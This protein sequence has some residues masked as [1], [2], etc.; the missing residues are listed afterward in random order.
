[1]SVL[2]PKR[3]FAV[4]VLL[5]LAASALANNPSPRTL[6]RMAFDE[7]TG[8]TV[9]FGG[10]GTLDQATG[11]IHSNAETWLL[12]GL[13]WAQRFPTTS[14]SARAAHSM[15]YD[16]KRNRVILFGGFTDP[17]S[18][19]G[20]PT[21]HNDT[22]VWENGNWTE[23]NT[24]N[25]PEPRYY[26]GI[27]YDSD[28]DR[29]VLYGG[30]VYTSDNK[31]T[32]A[33]YD[34]WEFDGTDW[35][36]VESTGAQKAGK[37]ALAYDQ[38]RK[39][40]LLVGL[41]DVLATTMFIYDAESKTWK[42]PSP[43]PDK[44]PSCANEGMMAYQKHKKTIG[45]VGGTCTA[46][47][48]TA[49]ELWEWNG[50]T[51]VKATINAVDRIT[52]AAFTYDSL[53]YRMLLFGGIIF[54]GSSPNSSMQMLFNNVWSYNLLTY[55][56][57]PRSLGALRTDSANGTAWL[58]GGLNEY[59]TGYTGDFWRYD[60]AGQ[61]LPITV[62]GNGPPSGCVTPL[63]A[64]DSNRSRF[65]VVCYGAELFEWNGSAWTSFSSVKSH[66]STRRFASMTYDETLK[67]VVLFGGYDDATGNY[68][69]DTWT[70]D[71]TNWA[72][73]KNNRPPNRGV[74]SMWYDPNIRKVVIYGGVGRNN[75]DQ[76][77]TRYDDMWSFDG[78]GWTQLSVQT[79]PGPRLGAQIGVDPNSKKL[80]L[81]GGLRAEK[82][83]DKT[84][85]QYFDND[86][87]QWDGSNNT[88]TKL[89]P[90]TKPAAREN[91]MM[92]WDPV[93]GQMVLFGGYA[94][95]F[96]LSDLWS[97]NGTNWTPQINSTGRRRAAGGK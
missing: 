75:A 21:F 61:W 58:Y 8:E 92:T 46:D 37:P 85:R 17:D 51:W 76:K 57:R 50:T 56:P 5:L 81:F 63:S 28:R 62:D 71:G 2:T 83:D 34:T 94:E 88:W 1:M 60:G 35:T 25:R 97:W 78:N 95:G 49:D 45:Y 90:A 53:T 55:R 93:L 18:P 24:P 27:A 30:V 38:S 52:G 13:R 16:S 26:S 91:G 77:V 69:Q 89:E 84:T 86:F 39:Q 79:T 47:T 19:T 3:V 43:A 59:S 29:V 80:L 10:R 4:V 33:V 7:H 32:Q 68:K 9:L 73:V 48:P 20:L 12:S 11:V 44:L 54:G 87:W 22:W 14:P 67:K 64:Y 65:V 15:V 70:W 6:A 42:S 72:E 41:N 40:M 36:R 23:I 66:P 96:Y 82:V 31:T 74:T